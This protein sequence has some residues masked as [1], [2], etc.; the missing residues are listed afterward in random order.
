MTAAVSMGDD[1]RMTDAAA[2]ARRR[3]RRW[4]WAVLAIVVIVAALAV[5]AELVA[6]AVLPGV[7][8]DVVIERLDLPVDQQLEVAAEGLLVPQLAAGRLDRLRLSTDAVAFGG[9]TAAVDVVAEGVPLRGGELGA[10]AGV[11]RVDE[12]QLGSLLAASDLP[13]DEVVLDEPD[14]T[15]TGSVQVL[16]L[17]LPVSVTVTPGARDGDVLL[18]PVAVQVNG[19]GL[20]LAELANRFGSPGS[21]I[22]EPQRI[23]IADQLPAGLTVSD[24]AVAE[25]ELVVDVAVDGAIATDRALQENG[26]CD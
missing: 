4:P 3:R 22:T 15:A 25:H 17:T 5:A 23:C 12:A 8:R 26:S 6:R 21:R 20:E 7:V 10:V 13:V 16:G 24:V 18:T 9:V 2:P 11:I 14:L 19:A 1:G